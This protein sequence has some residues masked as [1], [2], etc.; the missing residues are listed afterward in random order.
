MGALF[1][2]ARVACVRCAALVLALAGYPQAAGA[3]ERE[4]R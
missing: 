2:A 3:K 1:L 4:K